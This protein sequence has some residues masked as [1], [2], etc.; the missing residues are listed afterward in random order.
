MAFMSLWN[1]STQK[2]RLGLLLRNWYN[3]N[4]IVPHR[5]TLNAKLFGMEAFTIM[6]W[7]LSLWG[8]LVFFAL[9]F[10]ASMSSCSPRWIST[11][12][13]VY[14]GMHSAWSPTLAACKAACLCTTNCSGLDWYPS[15]LPHFRCWLHTPYS[16]PMFVFERPGITHFDIM[17]KCPGQ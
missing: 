16:R 13:H 3:L 2:S 9:C 6:T 12:T 15:V 7:P 14:G 5:F 17:Y 8:I 11:P 10:T 4:G 1:G